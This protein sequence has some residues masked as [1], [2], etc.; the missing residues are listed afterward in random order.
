[1]Y[2]SSRDALL[3]SGNVLARLLQWVCALAGGAVLLLI[4][5]VILLSQ[6]MLPGFSDASRSDAIEASP[7]AVIA[8]LAAL[9]LILAGLF[10]FFGNLRAMIASVGEGNPFAPENATRLNAMA[11]LFLGVKI[12]TVLVA[13]LRLHITSLM[14]KGTSDGNVLGFGLYD[15]DAILIVIILFVLA[16]VFRHGAAMR[17]D[18]KGTV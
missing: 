12:L 8:I 2:E 11:W 6:D 4:P 3:L 10:L 18:L 13:G 14:D 17:E 5:V 7:L 15:V 16:R 1:M 9:A